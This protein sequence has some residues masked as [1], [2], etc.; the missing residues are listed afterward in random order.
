MIPGFRRSYTRSIDRGTTTLLG[1]SPGCIM[2][3]FGGII[4][5]WNNKKKFKKS[6]REKNDFWVG[7]KR[8]S[9]VTRR[10]IHKITNNKWAICASRIQ[11]RS[12][13][14]K[15]N[16][17]LRRIIFGTN[18][19]QINSITPRGIGNFTG[20]SHFL[21]ATPWHMFFTVL[22]FEILRLLAR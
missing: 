3:I 15:F 20:S 5:Q 10:R 13:G 22:L 16:L 17:A 18:V 6:Y 14:I 12:V 8:G 4:N 2:A 7:S 11:L 21:I 9:C 19:A 1:N